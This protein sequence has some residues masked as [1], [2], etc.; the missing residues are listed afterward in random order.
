[1]NLHFQW[2]S[3]CDSV[4]STDAVQ[5]T[6]WGTASPVLKAC[7]SAQETLLHRMFICPALDAGSRVGRNL[8]ARPA[9][10]FSFPLSPPSIPQFF[11]LNSVCSFH[12]QWCKFAVGK[13]P[14]TALQRHKHLLFRVLISPV[15]RSA[16]A[17]ATGACLHLVNACL[18]QLSR[19]GL[20]LSV[21]VDPR[22]EKQ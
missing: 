6:H 15:P 12:L 8:Q 20:L 21:V 14:T 7:G 13:L 5:T 2:A 17:L 9:L 16:C 10:P 22:R 18:L 19:L 1:M 11:S 4:T 3:L